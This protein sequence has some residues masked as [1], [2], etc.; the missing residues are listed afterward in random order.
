MQSIISQDDPESR[1][2]YLCNFDCTDFML[3]SV[4]TARKENLLV[5]LLA[6]FAR[7]RFDLNM[8]AEL[9]V[10]ITWPTAK[11]CRRQQTS[12]KM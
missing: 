6:I 10:E 4:E 8:I 1:K 7:H 9:T 3:Q 11:V 12:Q 2:Q 5:E